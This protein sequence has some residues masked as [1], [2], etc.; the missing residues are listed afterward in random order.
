MEIIFSTV[1]V[2][3]ARYIKCLFIRNFYFADIREVDSIVESNSCLQCFRRKKKK[4]LLSYS[5]NKSSEE[6][7]YRIW[8]VYTLIYLTLM[9][10]SVIMNCTLR[11]SLSLSLS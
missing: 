2:D 6:E 10:T 9:S 3:T 8:S 4:S 11:K 7:L 1:H 5:Y